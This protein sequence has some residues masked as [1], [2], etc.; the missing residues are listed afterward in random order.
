MTTLL[1]VLVVGA[2]QGR[3]SLSTTGASLAA[4]TTELVIG[5]GTGALWGTM[6]Q[7]VQELTATVGTKLVFEYSDGHDLIM[8]NS[9]NYAGCDW[10]TTDVEDLTLAA[11]GCGAIGSC[12]TGATLA[13]LYSAVVTAV[14]EY[15]FTCSVSSGG[16]CRDGQKVKVTVT[17]QSPRP[18]PAQPSPEAPAGDS[19]PAASPSPPPEDSAAASLSGGA[20]GML[21]IAATTALLR[22]GFGLGLG[23]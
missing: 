13:N 1:A 23:V 15:Y 22:A 18:P 11:N 21:L 9:A 12:T 19:T 4:A 6:P 10:D 20:L 2:E 8:P 5:A 7:P 3:S 14:G 16:H 17:P